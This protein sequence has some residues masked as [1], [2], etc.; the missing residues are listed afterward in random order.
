MGFNKRY[1]T[2]KTT[3]KRLKSD[4][5]SQLYDKVDLFIFLDEFS[6]KVKELYVNGLSN[7]EIIVNIEELIEN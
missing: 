6:V 3:L 7:Q 5:L 1:V 2:K 4:T